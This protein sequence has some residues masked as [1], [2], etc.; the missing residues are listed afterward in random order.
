MVST[1]AFLGITCGLGKV[2]GPPRSIISYWRCATEHSRF[3]LSPAG[4]VSLA[5]RSQIHLG[6][7]P[8][9]GSLHF[10]KCPSPVMLYETNA[11][12]C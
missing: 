6:P 5:A 2:R 11:E 9:Q 12:R 3:N 4:F 1:F 10:P 7:H 8:L